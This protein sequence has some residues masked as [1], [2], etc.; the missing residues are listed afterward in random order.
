MH[1]HFLFKEKRKFIC[2]WIVQ[3]AYEP[4]HKKIYLYFFF[5]LVRWRHRDSLENQG[6][7]RRMVLVVNFFIFLKFK[8]LCLVVAICDLVHDV[9]AIFHLP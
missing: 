2:T 5:I 6:V 4:H 1:I 9:E 7:Q 3:S 8:L